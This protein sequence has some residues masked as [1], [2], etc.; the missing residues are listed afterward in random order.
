VPITV[1]TQRRPIA[2][3]VT[4]RRGRPTIPDAAHSAHHGSPMQGSS[5][6]SLLRVFVIKVHIDHRGP[7]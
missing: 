1:H 4:L 7:I 6:D 5:I 3:P 2:S